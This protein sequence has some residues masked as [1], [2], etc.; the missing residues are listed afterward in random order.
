MCFKEKEASTLSPHLAKDKIAL[1]SVQESLNRTWGT[2]GAAFLTWKGTP[3]VAMWTAVWL[4]LFFK[5]LFGF[6]QSVSL[7]DL[8]VTGSLVCVCNIAIKVCVRI[9]YFFSPF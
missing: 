4:I 8:V 2:P 5:F 7:E 9:A 3:M 6:L 1:V